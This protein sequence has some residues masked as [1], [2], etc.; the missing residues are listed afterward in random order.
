MRGLVVMVSVTVFVTDFHKVVFEYLSLSVDRR[1]FTLRFA[2]LLSGIEERG[3][4]SAIKLGNAL[5]SHLV[6]AIAGAIPEDEL[7]DRLAE[8]VRTVEIEP[9]YRDQEL[10]SVLKANPPSNPSPAELVFN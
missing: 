2:A 10:V 9:T 7:R 4:P 8:Q 1:E 6:L 3:E 5:Y